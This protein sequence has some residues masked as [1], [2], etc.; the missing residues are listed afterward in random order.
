MVCV[1]SQCMYSLLPSFA[2]ETAWDFLLC[3][4]TLSPGPIGDC[5]DPGTVS[6]RKT[7]Y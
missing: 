6:G 5:F 2:L 4:Q 1:V 7:G 3:W